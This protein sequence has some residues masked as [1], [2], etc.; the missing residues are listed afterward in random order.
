ME[1]Y[2][3]SKQEKTWAMIAHLSMLCGFIIP[4][5]NVIGPL[6]VWLIKK[7]EGPFV[8]QHGKEALNF[9]IS[10][11]IYSAISYLLVFVLIGFVLL[12]VL[13]VFFVI[14]LITAAIKANDGKPYRYPFTIR[15]IK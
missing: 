5:G 8:D 10:M 11:T 15:F 14:A 2:L 12:A 4:L 1:S 7:E 9:N 6:I 13:F 3:P